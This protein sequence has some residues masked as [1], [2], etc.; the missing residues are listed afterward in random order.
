[1]HHDIYH[2]IGDHEITR[3]RERSE[4]AIGHQDHQGR[5]ASAIE[6]LS[7]RKSPRKQL[8]SLPRDFWL[9]TYR[10]SSTPAVLGRFRSTV[11]PCPKYTLIVHSRS[12]RFR[13]LA[14][15]AQVAR[16]RRPTSLRLLRV[17]Q[18]LH[19]NII[20]LLPISV[21]LVRIQ[22]YGKPNIRTTPGHFRPSIWPDGTR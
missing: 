11:L 16:L 21:H 15:L 18:P 7:T 20:S 19:T 22:C 1:M 8:S 5:A 6:Q 9:D 13:H 10:P 3:S 12:L 2:Q 14:T 17:R 4:L